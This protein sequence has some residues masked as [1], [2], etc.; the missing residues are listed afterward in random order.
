MVDFTFF[1]KL[2]TWDKGSF[3]KVIRGATFGGISGR[4]SKD[5]GVDI[6]EIR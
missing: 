4:R 3:T 5:L 2:S 6:N 1:S